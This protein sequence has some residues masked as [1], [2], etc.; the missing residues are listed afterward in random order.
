MRASSLRSRPDPRLVLASLALASLGLSPVAHAQ[1]FGAWMTLS[2][3]TTG[4]ISIPSTA[5][6]NP[7]SQI[8]IEAWVNVSD[9]SGGGCSSIVGK[10]WQTSWWIGLCGTTFRS[11][12]KGSSSMRDTGTIPNGE[13]THVAVT[14]DGATRKH[15]INGEVVASWAETGA[16]PPS[17]D[18][19]DI[20][21]DVSLF[22]TPAGAIDEVRLWSVARTQAQ[23]RATI[24]VPLNTPQAGLVGVW[25]LNGNGID[26]V[27]AHNGAQGGS[28]IAFF[29]LPVALS[30]GSSTSTFFCLD[31]RFAVSAKFRVGAPGTAESQATALPCTGTGCGSSGI[32]WFFSADNWE[33]M[34]KSINGCALNS[35]YWLFSAATT[36]VF[37][38]LEA[39]D[40]RAGV[41]KVYFNY[42]GPPAPAVTD[43]SAFATCP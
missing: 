40:S 12:L 41:N 10:N 17:T 9:P 8:T 38:R 6:L 37:Y 28:G 1:P 26:V 19:M 14:Y 11:F 25:S 39:F 13:W 36:N 34:V 4:Y 32:F 3:P 42:P 30:C 5:A 16:L 23:I 22:H 33:V 29:T 27:G 7:S 18:P 24:N 35:R 15:Y 2:G 43:T 21:A 20:G 31:T